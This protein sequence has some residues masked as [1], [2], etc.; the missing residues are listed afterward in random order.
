MTTCAACGFKTR[1][2]E[3]FGTYEI[4]PVC[5]WED[6]GVQLANPACEGGANRESLIQY[7]LKWL[8]KYPMAIKQVD[9]FDRDSRWRPL[10]AG[11]ITIAENECQQQYWLNSAI[12]HLSEAYWQKTDNSAQLSEKDK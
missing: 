12:L 2:E 1:S 6:D 8:Q 5:D 9:E 11:E 10:N 7:Q 4:C 3:L